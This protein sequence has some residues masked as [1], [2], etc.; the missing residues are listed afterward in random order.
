M[1]KKCVEQMRTVTKFKASLKESEEAGQ[2]T[3]N[4]E[5]TFKRELLPL[6]QEAYGAESI[7]VEKEAEVHQQFD[8]AGRVI[9]IKNQ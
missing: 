4:A 9:V 6:F 7:K 3:A 5:S 2:K 8:T 1:M